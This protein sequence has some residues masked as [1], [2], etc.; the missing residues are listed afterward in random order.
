MVVNTV[1]SRWVDCPVLPYCLVPRIS[2]DLW[3]KCG[4]GVVGEM[5]EIWGCMEKRRH[6]E[7]NM[8]GR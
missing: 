3:G 5:G 8:I 4:Y 1:D 2:D 7:V 6:E